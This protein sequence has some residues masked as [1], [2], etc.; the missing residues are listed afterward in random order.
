MEKLF[1]IKKFD[2]D[3]KPLKNEAGDLVY[4]KFIYNFDKMGM[5]R[6]LM[7]IKFFE[8]AEK[9]LENPPANDQELSIL[10]FGQFDRRAWEAVLIRLIDG[11]PEF[12]NANK[13]TISDFEFD[14][15][16]KGELW[17]QLL[18]VKKDFFTKAGV[19]STAGMNELINLIKPLA[20]IQKEL[21]LESGETLPLSEIL[22]AVA[23]L[24]NTS[25]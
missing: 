11:E 10:M 23:A 18:E 4:T 3:G 7:G 20:T 5:G 22:G 13:T 1:K 25:S 19:K 21:K 17:S 15:L 12:Y 6:K 9:Q 24:T 14:E 16:G 8:L 2:K